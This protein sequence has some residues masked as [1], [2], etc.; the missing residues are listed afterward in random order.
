[1]TRFSITAILLM[2]GM[3]V[4]W[5]MLPTQLPSPQPTAGQ[6]ERPLFDSN[7]RVEASN[8]YYIVR[9]DGIPNH[10][11]AEFPNKNNP[12]RIQQQNYAFRIP[13]N[14]KKADKM[15]PLPMGPIGVAVNGIP[16][17]NP[18]N[19]EGNDAVSGLYAEVFDSCCGHPDQLGRYHY[20]KYPACLKSPFQDKAGEHSPLIGYAFDGYAIYGLLGENGKFPT[21]LDTCNGHTDK[22]R[23]YHYHATKK[24]P[25][26]LGGYR[27]VVA[28]QNFDRPEV[29]QR[30]RQRNYPMDSRSGEILGASGWG[31]PT[32]MRGN[33]SEFRQSKLRFH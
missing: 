32:P 24:F 16:F 29:H 14:P 15:T 10:P 22:E 28:P 13:R 12:N 17:Y 2:G 11:T 1:M 7:V 8:A 25:Y 20:H 27:G 9:S 4:G 6:E 31:R 33:Q 26:I 18:Y 21:D 5:M 19:A 30:Q 23:G 3:V